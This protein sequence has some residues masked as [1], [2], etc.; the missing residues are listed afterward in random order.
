M[1]ESGKPE[2]DGGERRS[3]GSESAVTDSA[4]ETEVTE[5]R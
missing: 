1:V 4:E 2:E 3:E 5:A